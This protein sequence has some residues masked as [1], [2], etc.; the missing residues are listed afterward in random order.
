M[1]YSVAEFKKHTRK[2]LNEALLHPVIITRF[3]D[4]FVL[5]NAGQLPS[6][7]QSAIRGSSSETC[8]AIAMASKVQQTKSSKEQQLL[9]NKPSQQ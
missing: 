5:T 7:S 3:D 1:R 6:N 4:E 8:P 9:Q 2:I